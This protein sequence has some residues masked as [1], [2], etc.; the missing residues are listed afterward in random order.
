MTQNSEIISVAEPSDLKV[1]SILGERKCQLNFK[2]FIKEVQNYV[3]DST[4]FLNKYKQE[5]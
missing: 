5:V 4:D 1:L 2:P 3:K